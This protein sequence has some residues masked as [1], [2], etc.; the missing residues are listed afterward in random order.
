MKS[1]QDDTE[2]IDNDEDDV[3]T[4]E[5]DIT[6]YPSDYTLKGLVDMFNRND[7]TIPDFQ[8]GFVWNIKQAS[9]LIES[10]LIGLPV[11]PIFFYIDDHNRNLVIDGQQ[12]LMSIVYF[13]EGFF[14]EENAKGKRQVF[15]LS[16]L[17]EN[18]KYYNKCYADLEDK[19][20]RKLDTSVL[21]AI[22]IRQLSPR[23]E[24]TCVYH[25]FE[26]LNT[27]GT[28]LSHQEIRNCV[29][30]GNFL[31]QL[32]LLNKEDNW[33]KVIGRPNLD[34][35][36]RDTELLLR[37][38]GL[39]KYL[40]FY[41]KPMKEFLNKV[42][43]RNQNIGEEELEQLSKRF[44]DTCNYI[45]DTLGEKPFNVRGPLN[46]SVLDSV[47]S[48][49]FNNLDSLPSNFRERFENMVEDPKF[50][51]LTSL[52]TTDEKTLNDRFDFVKKHLLE[53]ASY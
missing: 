6:S 37:V 16:G 44:Q 27:G 25:I 2:W 42:A 21:R 40:D 53:D 41:E 50:F 32:Q 8:R 31:R 1:N 36:Q 18:N 10:F 11:P 9:L 26:R 5:Y 43:L 7:I 33:R 24:N 14:G 28:P 23:N 12:R 49:V 13:F 52:G 48:V 39:S 35:K 22:N 4:I 15:K 46:T 20:K 3:V 29:F 30:R 51:N 45:V 17:K 34:K 19:D 47:F 38:I